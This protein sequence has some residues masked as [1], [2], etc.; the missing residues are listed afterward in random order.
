MSSIVPRKLAIYYG[1]PSVVNGAFGDINTAIDSF[2]DYKLLVFGQGL[3][4]SNHGDHGNTIA[5]ISHID[6]VNTFVF[7]YIDSTL[8]TDEILEKIQLWSAMGVKGIFLDRF[9]YDFGVTR[10][11]QRQIIW[12]VHHSC[13]GTTHTNLKAFVN[14]WNP[15]DVF[16]SV[17]DPVNNPTGKNTLLNSNDWYLAESFAVINST[18]DDASNNNYMGDVKDWEVKATKLVNYRNMY[19]TKIAAIA[20]SD[21]STFDQNQANYSYYASVINEFDA[22]GW[23]ENSYSATNGSMPFRQRAKVI[24]TKFINGQINTNGVLERQVNAGIHIDTNTH[25]VNIILD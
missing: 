24:G 22:W 19:S 4:N 2:K 17:M 18:Y 10:D 12:S 14:A 11:K 6:M 15:D 3:E 9:G 23:G 20:T 7:G 21:G 8:P 5:I 16:G 25:V 1:W 13:S